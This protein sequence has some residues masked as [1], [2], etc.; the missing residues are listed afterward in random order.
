MA[1]LAAV[2]LAAASLVP[3]ATADGTLTGSIDEAGTITGPTGTVAPGTYDYQVTDTATTHNYHLAGPGVNMS[4]GVAGTGSVTWTGL[5]LSD[6]EYVYQCD[7]HPI[8][9][10]SFR[11]GS[12]TSPP[13][14]PP[15]PPPPSP[16]PPP[17]P[18]ASL[19]TLRGSVGPGA[20]IA[21]KTASGSVAKSVA[22]GLYS[23]VVS[24]RSRADNF[25]LSGPGVDRRT[26]VAATGTVL[27]R[28]RLKPGVYAYRSDARPSLRKTLR[29]RA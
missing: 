2:A 11:V 10:G 22:A 26:R 7:V 20:R 28:V 27:W 4:T 13:P 16:P 12:A 15:P 8:I 24:D 6:G 17:P 18:A 21:L 23:V 29:V 9:N 5:V 25:H 1:G 14:A 3:L 19:P